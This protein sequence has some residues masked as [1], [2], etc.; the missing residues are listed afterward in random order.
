M[1]SKIKL[2]AGILL[3]I[4]IGVFAWWLVERRPEAVNQNPLTVGELTPTEKEPEGLQSV[5]MIFGGDI[6]AARG[7]R[8]SVNK[9]LGSD[10]NK[11]FEFLG[12]LKTFDVVFANLEGPASD[13]GTDLRNLYSFRMDISVIDAL[14]NAGINILSLANNHVGDWKKEAYEDTMT[15]LNQANIPFTGGGM[16]RAEAEAPTIIEKNGIKLGFLAFS[17]VGPSWMEVQEDNAGLLLAND[18]RFAEIVEA[19]AAQV[20]FLIVSFHFGDEYKP[21]HN[22]RQEYLAHR[23]V[24]HGAKIIIGHH[25][26]V[27]QDTE[28]YKDAY[29]AYSLGNFIFDQSWSEPTMI[30]ML[31]EI[32][33]REDGSMSVKKNITQI[34][35]FFQPAIATEGVEEEIIFE[36]VI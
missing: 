5:N 4:L 27:V 1:N 21:I 31:L 3:L 10:Y 28:V 8:A 9:N 33:L 34:N 14:K 18:P 35:K 11:L 15:R 2:F 20:N 19:A 25:P 23:A 7:V 12:F 30:G 16:T 13:K 29:I 26:H 17:D 6:M 36:E 24:D 32:R 22:N